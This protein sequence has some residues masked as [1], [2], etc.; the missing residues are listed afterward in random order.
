M[1]YKINPDVCIRCGQCDAVCPVGAVYFDERLDCYQIDAAKCQD[2]G[3]CAQ[4]CP[5]GAISK[6]E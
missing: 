6:A 5:V 3:T 2:C 4:G 1:A